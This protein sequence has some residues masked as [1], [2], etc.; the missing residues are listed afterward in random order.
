MRVAVAMGE[1]G[2]EVSITERGVLIEL[3]VNN[4][5]RGGERPGKDSE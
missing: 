2:F 4:V 3:Q 1:V 5:F